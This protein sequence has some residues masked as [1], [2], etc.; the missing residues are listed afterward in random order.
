MCLGASRPWRVAG[1]RRVD[2][3]VRRH[4]ASF[5]EE[6]GWTLVS[7]EETHALSPET[8]W[9]P[10]RKE[11]VSLPPGDAVKLLFDI[12]TKE[13]GQ[14]VDRGVDRLWVIVKR[15]VGTSYTGVLDSDPGRAAGLNLSPGI[16]LSFGPEHVIAI[17]RPPDGY[18]LQKY[19]P[20]FFED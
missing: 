3:R 17:K 2:R 13:D 15:R 8:F 1:G 7:G 6:D 20:E 5:F 9:I 19:G 14:V 10:E 12:E 4:S 18:V 11:R 16:E